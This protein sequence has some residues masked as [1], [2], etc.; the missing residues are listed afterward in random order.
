MAFSSFYGTMVLKKGGKTMK[1]KAQLAVEIVIGLAG[2]LFNGYA[3]YKRHE[4]EIKEITMPLIDLRKKAA[5]SNPQLI[6]KN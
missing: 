6:T 4:V 3:F 5:N 2:L 1:D